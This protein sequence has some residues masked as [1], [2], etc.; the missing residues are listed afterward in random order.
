MLS[1]AQLKDA[2]DGI[3][4]DKSGSLDF[5]EVVELAKTLG[6]T[7][8]KATLENMFKSIDTNNDGKL[9]FEEFLAW[10]RVG[11]DSKMGSMIKYHLEVQ[12]GFRTAKAKM[13]NNNKS[14]MMLQN[15]CR[16]V[17][18]EIIDGDSAKSRGEI[19]LLT[20][21]ENK[22]MPEILK[23]TFPMFDPTKT[24]AYL[25]IN[26][27]DAEKVTEAFNNLIGEGIA[28]A[29]EQ[30]SEAG[31]ALQDMHVKTGVYKEK[32][33]IVLADLTVSAATVSIHE[34]LTEMT[35]LLNTV[36]PQVQASV[37]SNMTLKDVVGK[38]SRSQNLT[39]EEKERLLDET[40]L[41]RLFLSGFSARA[42]VDC[43]EANKPVL[44]NFLLEKIGLEPQEVPKSFRFMLLAF[45]SCQFRMRLSPEKT[46]NMVM[47]FL[48][49]K[50]PDVPD[51]ADLV[52][53]VGLALDGSG[54][55]NAYYE[56]PFFRNFVD[57]IKEYAL[58]DVEVGFH[59]IPLNASMKFQTEGIK[60]LW[61]HVLDGMVENQN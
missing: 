51:G 34:N 41:L 52:D 17:D 29:I 30:S 12:K 54:T 50:N 3:D 15:S 37:A 45:N 42:R 22:R 14:G 26:T 32:K 25:I 48:N 39:E 11:K 9:S 58:C 46:F 4:K 43:S 5:A 7:V 21:P 40:N 57:S 16:L 44:R 2:F 13:E 19:E 6:H 1:S 47:D 53:E 60:E 24:Y 59:S 28:F 35:E 55:L 27:K 18:F 10:Y 56:L 20:G 23:K 33:V 49:Q 31:A 61:E 38:V 8:D 36:K